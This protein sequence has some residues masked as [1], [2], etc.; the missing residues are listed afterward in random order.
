[1][2]KGFTFIEI[3]LVVG[4]IVAITAF[5]VPLSVSF[6]ARNDL[7][8]AVHTTAQ[9]LRRTQFLSQAVDGDIS[10]GV[11]IQSSSIVLFKGSSFALRD[12]AFDEQFDMPATIVP[13]GINEVVFSKFSGLSQATGTIVFATPYEARTLTINEKG[14]IEY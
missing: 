11:K 13:S 7:D 4:A 10:W 9:G 5:T 1:M 8:I 14:T 12:P 3:L 2:E 6:Q